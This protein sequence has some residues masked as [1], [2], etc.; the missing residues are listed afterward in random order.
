MRNYAPH[1]PRIF[2]RQYYQQA[3]RATLLPT[4]IGHQNPVGSPP[5]EFGSALINR[6]SNGDVLVNSLGQPIAC[7]CC[8]GTYCC[9]PIGRQVGAAFELCC[10]GCSI[11]TSDCTWGNYGWDIRMSISWTVSNEQ[12][13]GC[14]IN[15]GGGVAAAF[16]EQNLD[17]YQSGFQG[18]CVFS[19]F[20]PDGICDNCWWSPVVLLTSDVGGDNPCWVSWGVRASQAGLCGQV[21]CGHPVSSCQISPTT[22]PMVFNW[23]DPDTTTSGG[24]H[25][26]SPQEGQV[27]V[28]GGQVSFTPV[29]LTD[30]E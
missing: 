2:T 27:T 4:V 26:C 5:A 23:N 22:C 19:P 6:K 20:G 18:Q 12:G 25:P 7:E 14:V 24:P 21:F 29:L 3:R 30:R 9:L 11:Q 13:C 15:G 10:G 1:H 28:T 17:G 8:E 16:T